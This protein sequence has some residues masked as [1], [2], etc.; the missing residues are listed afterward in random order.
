MGEHSNRG[1]WIGLLAALVIWQILVRPGVAG[2]LGY[3][4]GLSVPLLVLAGAFGAVG[5]GIGSLIW[6]AL[7]DRSRRGP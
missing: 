2:A 3:D 7:H 4:G 6:R 5:A 1:A